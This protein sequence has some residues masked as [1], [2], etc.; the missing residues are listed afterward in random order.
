MA[1]ATLYA[2]ISARVSPLTRTITEEKEGPLVG[3]GPGVIGRGMVT[4]NS[5]SMRVDS[6]KS[7]LG[8]Y[9]AGMAA[10]SFPGQIGSN[11]IGSRGDVRTNNDTFP[12]INDGKPGYIDM[13]NG[14]VTGNPYA[15]LP[16]P[17]GGEEWDPIT[18]ENIDDGRGGQLTEEDK[19]YKQ[20]QLVFPPLSD[21]APPAPGAR[22]FTWDR[23]RS[24]TLPGGNYNNITITKGTLVVPPGNYG[25]ID[26]TNSKGTIVLG[27]PGQSTVYN[28]QGFVAGAQAT[29]RYAGPVTINVKSSLDVGAGTDVS[30]DVQPASIRW[31]FVGG[32]SER[33]YLGGHSAIVGV[34]YAPNNDIEIRGTGDF[35]GAVAGRTVDIR[36]TGAFHV[37]EDAVSGVLSKSTYFDVTSSIVGYSASKYS[38]WRITQTIN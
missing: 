22:D 16:A 23:D 2:Y 34:F 17:A 25:T 13:K 36:G 7:S 19:K 11:N 9:G 26:L 32:A 27:V 12:G 18:M 20:P 24:G 33:V 29:I 8:R 38:L 31:N 3:A 28:L 37:D 14:T 30:S 15:T 10:G 35:Y 6:Y 4:W 5:S 21:P 1:N